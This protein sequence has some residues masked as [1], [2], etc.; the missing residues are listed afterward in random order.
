[1]AEKKAPTIVKV[2]FLVIWST[3][4]AAYFP[5]DTADLPE[6]VATSLLAEP[7]GPAVELL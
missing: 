1:M 3:P 6:E 5:G 7:S 4:D 2:K